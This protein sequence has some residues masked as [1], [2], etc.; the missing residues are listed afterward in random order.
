[1]DLSKVGTAYFDG[2]KSR[3][4]NKMGKNVFG[5]KTTQP[6]DFLSTAVKYRG[7]NVLCKLAGL[8]HS[9]KPLNMVQLPLPLSRS[10]VL[11]F[12]RNYQ[13]L[14]NGLFRYTKNRQMCIKLAQ[15]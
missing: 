7:E 1:M 9:R 12:R 4:L 10:R 2:K 3:V 14:L 13:P 8:A 6:D 5:N 11:I 15:K